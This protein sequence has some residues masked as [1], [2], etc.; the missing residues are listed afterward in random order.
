[1]HIQDLPYLAQYS[2]Y[3]SLD[4][5]I[6]NQPTSPDPVYVSLQVEREAAI[7]FHACI[8]LF[9][10]AMPWNTRRLTKAKIL[11]RK[12]DLPLLWEALPHSHTEPNMPL[13][14]TQFE[15]NV[16]RFL[17]G[18]DQDLSV[19]SISVTLAQGLYATWLSKAR[20]FV[21]VIFLAMALAYLI[22]YFDQIFLAYQQLDHSFMGVKR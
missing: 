19:T 2:Y 3:L 21:E 20:I 8:G 5:V 15:R 4:M 16:G 1:M 6:A 10:R 17:V 9:C 18:P 7:S 11:P 22:Q 12:S 14:C 13:A